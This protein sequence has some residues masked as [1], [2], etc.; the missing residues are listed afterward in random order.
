MAT[1]TD[2]TLQPEEEAATDSRRQSNDL[3]RLAQKHRVDKWGSHWYAQHYHHHFKHL[4]Y[5]RINLL[6]IGVGGYANPAAGGDSLRMWEEYFPQATV[7]GVDIH[8][9]RLHERGRIKIRRG[10]QADEEFL[11]TLCQEAGSFDIIIDDGSHVNDH[12]IKSF[13]VLFP[14]LSP[15]GIYTVEDIQTSYW[16]KFGGDSE[17]LAN[18]TT[19]I[20][21]FKQFIDSLNYEERIKPGYQPSY[22]DKHVVALHCYHNLILINKGFNNEGSNLLARNSFRAPSRGTLSPAPGAQRGERANA[23]K[24]SGGEVAVGPGCV[25][26]CPELV[27]GT[28]LSAPGKPADAKTVCTQVA[29]IDDNLIGAL[30]K[31]GKFGEV[32]ESFAEA[33]ALHPDDH[34]AQFNLGN[35]LLERG[36]AEAAEACYRRAIA[37][38]PDHAPFHNNLGNALAKQ[39]KSDDAI[40]CYRQALAIHPDHA[41]AHFN[42]ANILR[43]QGKLKEAEAGYRRTIECAPDHYAAHFNLALVLQGQARSAEAAVSCRRALAIRPDYAVAYNKLA[44]ILKFQGRAGEATSYYRRAVEL[45]PDAP[46]FHSNLLLCLQY[47]PAMTPGALLTE[48]QAYGAKLAAFVG[49]SLPAPAHA[50]RRDPDKRINIGY[51]SA[52]LHQHPVGFLMMPVLAAHDRQG[53]A[54]HCYYGN[55]DADGVTAFLKDRADVWRSTVDV[56]DD[57]LAAMIRADGIDILVDLAGHTLNNRLPVFARKPAPVQA[58][59][60]GYFGTTG[61]AAIDYLITDRHLS[62]PG[63]ERYAVEKLARLPDGY[64]CWAMPSHAPAVG[65]LTASTPGA[66]TFGCFNN[67]AKIN[68]LVIALWSRLLRDLPASRLVLKTRELA[69]AAVRERLLGLF[70][71]EGISAARITLEGP[72][73]HPEYLRRYN[74]IDIALDPFPYSGGLITVDALWMGVPV[75]SMPGDRFAS[76][77]SLTYLRVSGLDE[78]VAD[79]PENYLRIAKELAQDLPRLAALRAGLRERVSASPLRRSRNFTRGLEAAL[80]AMWRDWCEQGPQRG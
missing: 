30:A 32:V 37:L 14:V 8:D 13:N 33:A 71:I 10:S 52:D 40:D 20:G 50:N 68:P 80:R 34:E 58:T 2:S 16:P 62:P 78:L 60:A 3:I 48:H 29:V 18:E 28:A 53:F 1:M 11:H 54:V 76:R 9:K 4:R 51:V 72:S 39:G 38:Q 42:L 55:R 64:L 49:A 56:G 79:G 69:D 15:H 35:A 74:D 6:E 77:H 25:S 23:D 63:S 73:A 19:I 17:N 12:V 43:D 21:F 61:L 5:Q 75:V 44:E 66:L 27:I 47:D 46:G 59:W 7:Y 36:Q 41:R 45:A 65:P 24:S 67:L 70:A 31:E 26:S 57:D 22:V